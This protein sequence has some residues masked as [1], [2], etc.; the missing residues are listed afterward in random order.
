MSATLSPAGR[1]ERSDWE[2]LSDGLTWDQAASAF[3]AMW[4]RPGADADAQALLQNLVDRGALIP[5]Q[6]A[7]G[8]SRLRKAAEWP[9]RDN[10]SHQEG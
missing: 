8:V 1:R 10:G 2:R 6:G 9:E 4:D 3:V 5:T 7:D